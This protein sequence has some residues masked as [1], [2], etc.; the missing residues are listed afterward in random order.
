MDELPL[1]WVD[2]IPKYGGSENLLLCVGSKPRL[3]FVRTLLPRFG[4]RRSSRTEQWT[5]RA[6]GKT[7]A[8]LNFACTVLPD[9]GVICTAPFGSLG[10]GTADVPVNLL[11]PA[12]ASG[13]RC[14]LPSMTK[15]A[16]PL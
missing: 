12:G 8:Q 4:L 6:V 11:S 1:S 15:M 3:E 9:G 10:I 14:G 16:V 13:M 7:P 5:S 2:L